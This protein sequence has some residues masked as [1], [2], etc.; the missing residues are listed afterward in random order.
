[1]FFFFFFGLQDSCPFPSS[2]RAFGTPDE[3]EVRRNNGLVYVLTSDKQTKQLIKQQTKRLQESACQAKQAA[4][5]AVVHQPRAEPVRFFFFFFLFVFTKER[6]IN[7][8]IN[9][10]S[11]GKWWQHAQRAYSTKVS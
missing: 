4:N 8:Q 9:P 5:K 6:T 3:R 7:A 10:T 11:C 2:K 1:M